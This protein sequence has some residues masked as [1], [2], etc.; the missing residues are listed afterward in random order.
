MAD[1][2]ARGQTKLDMVQGGLPVPVVAERG[3][4]RFKDQGGGERNNDEDEYQHGPGLLLAFHVPAFIEKGQFSLY[5]FPRAVIFQFS[6]GMRWGSKQGGNAE[7]NKA[8]HDIRAGHPE[9]LGAQ[10][11]TGIQAENEEDREDTDREPSQQTKE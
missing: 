7:R 10:T 9:E 11:G 5:F 1:G 4:L 6:D 8:D 3:N 2:V